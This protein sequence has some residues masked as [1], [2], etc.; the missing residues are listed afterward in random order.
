MDLLRNPYRGQGLPTA[1]G[2]AT[3]TVHS[4]AAEVEA[5]LARCPV[6]AATPLLELPELARELG[7]AQLH[8]KD[9]RARMGLGSFKALGAAHVIA[10]MAAARLD[11][12]GAPADIDALASALAGVVFACASAGNH[13]LSVAAGAPVFGATAVV[14]LAATVPD[15]FEQQLRDRGARVI[16]AGHDY[17]ASM[18]AARADAEANGWILLSDSSWPGYVEVPSRVMEG[19]LAIAAEVTATLTR[20]PTHILLQAGVG[21]FAAALAARFRASWGDAP[22]IVVAEPEAAPALIASIRAGR[23]VTTDGPASSM[24]RLDCKAPSHL[25]LGELARLADV[26]VTLSDAEVDATVELLRRHGVATTP[27]GAAGLAA[28]HHGGAHR[29]A[30]GSDMDGRLLAIATEAVPEPT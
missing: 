17:E 22:T 23:P 29:E 8:L 16:R 26:F 27:S 1:A 13:G 21:G 11:R 25:A 7:V 28:V 3:G 14:Y 15:A 2:L 19:Y 30:L 5:L 10:R 4:D 20:P 12:P 18:A 9:E 6:A 24:G